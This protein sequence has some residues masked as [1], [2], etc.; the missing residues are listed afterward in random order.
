M[1]AAGRGAS[2]LSYGDNIAPMA[3]DARNDFHTGQRQEQH[4]MYV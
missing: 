1:G 2:R 3:L 4:Y